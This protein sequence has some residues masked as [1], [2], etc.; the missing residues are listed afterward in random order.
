[1]SWIPGASLVFERRL[2]VLQVGPLLFL[3]P[4]AFQVR[5]LFGGTLVSSCSGGGR[6]VSFVSS[7]GVRCG[8]CCVR[9]LGV[10]PGDF[11]QWV[12]T[13]DGAEDGVQRVCLCAT[14]V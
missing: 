7:G 4:L 12:R 3:G 10:F 8:V 5:V 11:R 1:M 6:P 2:V 13:V 9:V 14:R